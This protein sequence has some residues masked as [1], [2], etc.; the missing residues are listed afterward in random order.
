MKKKLFLIVAGLLVVVCFQRVAFSAVSPPPSEYSPSVAFDT[1]N[2]RYLLTYVTVNGDQYDL[3]GEVLNADATVFQGPFLISPDTGSEKAAAVAFDPENQKFLVVWEDVGYIYGRFVDPTG[4]PIDDKFR[5]SNILDSES[6]LLPGPGSDPAVAY[7]NV[8]HRFLVVWTDY[9]ITYY[10]SIYGQL[11]NV[12]ADGFLDGDNFPISN[13]SQPAFPSIGYDNVNERFLVVWQAYQYPSGIDIYGQLVSK[14]GD[15]I[16][17]DGNI[18]SYNFPVTDFPGK[19]SNPALAYDT[20]D[21]KFLVTWLDT[22]FETYLGTLS[23]RFVK[24]DGTLG[25]DI[26]AISDPF[27]VGGFE[28]PWFHSAVAYDNENQ[29]FLAVW[30]DTRNFELSGVDIYGQFLDKDGRLLKLNGTPGI[31]N[32]LI[33]GSTEDQFS[34]SIAYNS[35]DPNFLVAFETWKPSGDS[36]VPQIGLALVNILQR[37]RDFGLVMVGAS[38]SRNFTITNAGTFDLTVKSIEVTEGNSSMFTVQT[39]GPNPCPSLSPKLGTTIE[40][41][42]CTYTVI[43]SP[44]SEGVKLTTLRIISDAVNYPVIDIPLKGTGVRPIIKVDP[45]THDFGPVL[46]GSS[47]S[48]I[49]TIS[50]EAGATADLS[51]S[52]IAISGGDSGLFS[53]TPG[54]TNAC[55]NLAPIL[56]PSGSCTVTVTFSPAETTFKS[57]TL[58]IISNDP[59]KPVIDV[60]LSGTGFLPP[61]DIEVSSTSLNFGVVVVD[62]S[63]EQT[64]T[65]RN[66]GTSELVLGN[67][68]ALSPPFA[69]VTKKEGSCLNGQVLPAQGQCTV[70]IRFSPTEERN[71]GFTSTFTIPSN[72][73]D[74]DEN[75]V[76]VA[77]NGSTI[78]Q[79]IKVDPMNVN[80]GDVLK[81]ANLDQT[82]TVWN[83][84]T[85][86]LTLTIIG[87]PLEPFIR[88]EGGCLNGQV[89]S[90]G[91][92]CTM[93][94]RFAPQSANENLIASSIVISSND[95]NENPVTVTLTGRGVAPRIEVTPGG[96]SFGDVK[97]AGKKDMPISVRNIGTAPLSIGTIGSP[98]GPFQLWELG[99][100]AE[101]KVLGPGEDCSMTVRF[102]PKKTGAFASSFE[103]ASND[104]AVRVGLKGGSGPDLEWESVSLQP[105]KCRETK[106]GVKCTA[107]GTFTVRNRGTEAAK[108]VCLRFFLSDGEGGQRYLTQM[109]TK[110]I[111]PNKSQKIKVQLNLPNVQ[112]GAIGYINAVL[113]TN[114]LLIEGDETNNE[115][116][117]TGFTLQ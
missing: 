24:G 22:D 9:R 111:Q 105:P 94:V 58:K 43:F 65:V 50:N 110:R 114:D 84:G 117:S 74:A 26:I 37:P 45:S 89:L 101:G 1:I 68:G 23:G 90:P 36:P 78:W 40:D 25:A 4:L 27:D 116:L 10:G 91:A 16:D 107:L 75:P 6:G 54:G 102:S 29:R 83:E 71:E 48:H 17:K 33:S 13:S 108:P 82:I 18:G 14:N 3:V 56:A 80:F 109:A 34:P 98:E 28:G 76:I 72:D 2:N 70:T 100:C 63:S 8:D 47:S 103:I 69:R 77:L 95:R 79:D 11:V 88:L 60:A 99:T 62:S 53:V 96:M 106:S 15:L 32:S 49:F 61:P 55:T 92:Y 104:R 41:N 46:K 38:Y 115:M 19:Q 39:G 93:V 35:I 64:I 42:S 59:D 81:N 7:D 66:V 113:D 112:K 85:Y 5:I 31:E 21:Q 30:T 73:P 86:D 44:I 52:S 20:R 87:S 51:V 67:F 57:T 97:R 12:N